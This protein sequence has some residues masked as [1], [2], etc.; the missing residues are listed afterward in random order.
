MGWCSVVVDDEDE[1]VHSVIGYGYFIRDR[2][3]RYKENMQSMRVTWQNLRRY[4]D[5]DAAESALY[6]EE[7]SP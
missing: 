1:C 7:G 5:E 4:G 6:F 3:A 2:L